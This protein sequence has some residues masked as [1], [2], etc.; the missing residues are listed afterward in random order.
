MRDGKLRVVAAVNLKQGRRGK[1]RKRGK[2]QRGRKKKKTHRADDT[3]SNF[4]FAAI[5]GGFGVQIGGHQ[6]WRGGK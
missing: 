3:T 1:G 5:S 6:L 2:K 4:G